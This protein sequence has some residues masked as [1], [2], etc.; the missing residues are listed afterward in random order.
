MAPVYCK[1]SISASA[2]HGKTL[3]TLKERNKSNSQRAATALRELIFSGALAPGTDHLET[4]LA[5]RLGMSRT[6]VREAVLV[7]E[8]QGLLEVRPRKGVRI[9]PISPADMREIYEVLTALESMAAE[10][11]ARAGYTDDDLA[12]LK[13]AID[14][15][16]AALA[17][18]DRAAWA[19]ADERFHRELV[20]LGRNERV[21][22]IFD[23]LSDQVR[24][25]KAMTLYVRPLPVKSNED[26]RTVCEAIRNGDAE[27][28]RETHHRHRE[29][30]C[31]V[32]VE[33]LNR[34]GLSQL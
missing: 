18:D 3:T 32:I 7:L 29:Q 21:S 19:L 11:A 33:L 16:N 10:K 25:A 17:E 9:S 8:G 28:A 27:L 24:R 15:M 2:E 31:E 12:D 1:H 5:E 20:R 6:P 26:H 13:G 23:R 14:D 4:E 34:F 30:A 22:E